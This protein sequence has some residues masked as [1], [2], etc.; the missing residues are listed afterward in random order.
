MKRLI[1][2]IASAVTLMSFNTKLI[3]TGD[4]L[5]ALKQ[6]DA[7]AIAQYFDSFVDI[8]L[9][10][11]DEVKNLSKTQASITLRDFYSEQKITGFELTSQREMGGTGYITGKLKSEGHE[12]NITI[13]VKTKGNSAVIVSVRI[14]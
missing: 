11:K 9:P 13:M 3:D 12:C 8:K 14:S 4:I 5:N 2:F 6:A 7:T 1:T 10:N